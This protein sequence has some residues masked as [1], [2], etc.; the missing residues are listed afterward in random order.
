MLP[1]LIDAITWFFRIMWGMLFARV[2]LSWFPMA[3]GNMLM[4]L[5]YAFTEPLLLPIRKLIQRSPLG[6]PG[7]MIDF[8]ILI[9]FV[10]LRIVEGVLISFLLTL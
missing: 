3:R 9:A 1:L 10:L 7:M 2:I 8:S 4:G 5:L 6:G